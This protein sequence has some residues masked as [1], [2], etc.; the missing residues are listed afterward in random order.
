MANDGLAQ[1][2]WLTQWLL[3][4]SW[5]LAWHSSLGHWS[6]LDNLS[7][8]FHDGHMERVACLENALLRR[9]NVFTSWRRESSPRQQKVAWIPVWRLGFGLRTPG[10][11]QYSCKGSGPNGVHGLGGLMEYLEACMRSIRHP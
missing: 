11:Q 10:L 6:S 9:R 3:D 7:D 8:I 5:V 2:R 1:W 4:F